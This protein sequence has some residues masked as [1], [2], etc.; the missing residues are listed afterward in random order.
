MAFNIVY[1]MNVL[2]LALVGTCAVSAG[3]RLADS[4]LLSDFDRNQAA[5]NSFAA[6]VTPWPGEAMRLPT[7]SSDAAQPDAALTESSTEDTPN[8]S[9]SDPSAA[10]QTDGAMGVSLSVPKGWL[11]FI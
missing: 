3:W 7:S 6:A 9:L 2:M 1:E 10:A 8:L 11:R 5:V 4:L